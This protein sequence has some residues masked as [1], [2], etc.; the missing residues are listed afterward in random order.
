M[1][2]PIMANTEHDTVW[3]ESKTLNMHLQVEDK[4]LRFYE[5]DTGTKLLTHK[6]TEDELAQ[7]KAAYQKLKDTLSFPEHDNMME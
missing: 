4:S 5:A 2:Q 1:Y 7:L 3:L 6:E